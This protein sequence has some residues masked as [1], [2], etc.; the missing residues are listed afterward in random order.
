[1][2]KALI[3]TL[4]LIVSACTAEARDAARLIGFGCAVD[5]DGIMVGGTMVAG[6]CEGGLE[7]RMQGIDAVEKEQTCKDKDGE[8]WQCGQASRQALADLIKG[9]EVTCHLI[10]GAITYGR[11]VG[12]CFA[13]ETDLNQAQTLEGWAI[14]YRKYS[15]RY[16]GEEKEAKKARRGIW[17]GKFEKPEKWRRKH[18]R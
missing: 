13:G 6:R 10:P 3:I 17:R 12:V 5:G 2:G 4:A 18:Y 1:M 16:V 8:V 15:N 14:A 11:P 7:V 9:A